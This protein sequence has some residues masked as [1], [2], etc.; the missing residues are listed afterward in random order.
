MLRPGREYWAAPARRRCLRISQAVTGQGAITP[1]CLQRTPDQPIILSGSQPV[2]TALM[3]SDSTDKSA[4]GGHPA[5]EGRGEERRDS[6]EFLNFPQFHFSQTGSKIC[7]SHQQLC[8]TNGV[9]NSRK[10]SDVLFLLP[11]PSLFDTVIMDIFWTH[12]DDPFKT[13]PSPPS[14][15][16][17][18]AS[19]R[20]K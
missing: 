20:Q 17:C 10:I 8:G 1:H 14:L 2:Q 15:S 6:T 16:S 5:M 18:S 9:R 4:I 11:S 19:D 3:A 13:H 12:C 7:C